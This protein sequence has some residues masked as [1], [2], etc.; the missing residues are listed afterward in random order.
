MGKK[1]CAVALMAC[2]LGVCEGCYNA[3]DVI[4]KG[5]SVCYRR[6]PK[7]YKFVSSDYV[8]TNGVV[9]MT[10]VFKKKEK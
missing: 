6:I 7:N 10:I 4:E 5:D 1:V 3:I 2:A 9:T 8:E